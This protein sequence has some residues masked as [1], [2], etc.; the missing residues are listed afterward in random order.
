MQIC[1][2]I[3]LG[4]YLTSSGMV[5]RLASKDCFSINVKRSLREERE[6]REKR[7]RPVELV[8]LV[9]KDKLSRKEKR[10]DSMFGGECYVILDLLVSYT[11]K[12]C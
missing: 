10:R 2:F 11:R 4:R 9:K 12:R 3:C 8:E 5:K 7:R 1:V 6:E